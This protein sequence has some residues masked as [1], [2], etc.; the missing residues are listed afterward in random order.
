MSHVPYQQ[1]LDNPSLE[2]EKFAADSGAFPASAPYIPVQNDVFSSLN[3]IS[4]DIHVGRSPLNF[5]HAIDTAQAGLGNRAT[6]DFVR[7]QY[8]DIH[9]LA[10]QGFQDTP[11]GFP[12]KAQIQQAFG[13]KHD[14]GGLRAYTGPAARAANTELGSDAYHKGGQVAFSNTPTL[15]NAAHEATHYVQ[16]LD[17]TRLQGGVGEANDVYERHAGRVADAVVS[18]E[19][20]ASLLDQAPSDA[21]ASATN[22][23]DSPLQ[24]AGGRM[25]RR[26]GGMGHRALPGR[27]T[28]P[29]Q[30]GMNPKVMPGRQG[31]SET[32]YGGVAGLGSKWLQ[33]QKWRS[34][35]QYSTDRRIRDD[36]MTSPIM[37]GYQSGGVFDLWTSLYSGE[38]EPLETGKSAASS[39]PRAIRTDKIRE[40]KFGKS[41]VFD[42]DG[43]EYTSAGF[44]PLE[45]LVGPL[46]GDE[47]HRFFAVVRYAQFREFDQGTVNVH[48]DVSA[49]DREQQEPGAS[50]EAM[51]NPRAGV[52]AASGATYILG[53]RLGKQYRVQV[54]DVDN[55]YTKGVAA[56]VMPIT[57]ENFYELRDRLIRSMTPKKPEDGA[58]D[59]PLWQLQASPGVEQ[60][61]NCM[62]YAGNQV[63]QSEFLDPR[64]NELFST[65]R[66]S[67]AVSDFMAAYLQAFKLGYGR[68]YDDEDSVNRIHIF[69]VGFDQVYN[70]WLFQETG[71]ERVGY[72]PDPRFYNEQFG[73]TTNDITREF[74]EWVGTEKAFKIIPDQQ[75]G[76]PPLEPAKER[77]PNAFTSSIANPFKDLAGPVP[78]PSGHTDYAYTALVQS[79]TIRD[80]PGFVAAHSSFGLYKSDRPD[81]GVWVH[82]V[83][84][85]Y[86]K[87]PYTGEMDDSPSRIFVGQHEDS[88]WAEGNIMGYLARTSV[89][90]MPAAD[91]SL[92]ERLAMYIYPID[93]FD[94]MRERVAETLLS[95]QN[96]ARMGPYWQFENTGSEP[97]NSMAHARSMESHM[98]LTEHPDL[99]IPPIQTMREVLQLWEMF[100]K[101]GYMRYPDSPE[102]A[103]RVAIF[104]A[105]L[106]QILAPHIQKRGEEPLSYRLP[107]PRLHNATPTKHDPNHSLQVKDPGEFLHT[108]KLFDPSIKYRD[109]EDDKK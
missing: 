30:R 57:E 58:W 25:L 85:E 66:K 88:T 56:V 61:A 80:E 91:K 106:D 74:R 109:D 90:E 28:G 18:G 10:L 70:D 102:M 8:Q 15:E 45:N 68:Y 63:K 54:R 39:Y 29:A 37:P 17:A 55:N 47:G 76:M 3:T 53:N 11:Q 98:K 94:E 72:L 35:Y 95:P 24:M 20:A 65:A 46:P 7:Q 97:G 43:I 69:N 40:N 33:R 32:D 16:N 107:P 2:Q 75:A 5:N 101:M 21:N 108:K 86:E 49:V 19:S 77:Y 50:M 34:P 23:A 6:L 96:V 92:S 38:Q 41:P 4:N 36:S 27:R 60:P 67:N 31:S 12:F 104:N 84:D 79:P 93:N 83:R 44:N 22:A 87:N 9:A 82:L 59:Y 103:E 81:K 48:I 62:V 73:G 89:E 100:Q 52:D 14:I 26:L 1:R 13:P 71:D 64:L 42:Y 51:V 78:G 105:W 99:E